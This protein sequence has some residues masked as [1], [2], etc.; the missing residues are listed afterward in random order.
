MPG[1]KGNRNATKHGV[2]GYL[3]VGT[4]PKGASY[5]RRRADTRSLLFCRRLLTASP[6]QSQ[7]SQILAT[8]P[9]GPRV[10]FG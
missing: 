2:H 7:I 9:L 10:A 1:T 3:A 8:F 4:L 6:K 5:I